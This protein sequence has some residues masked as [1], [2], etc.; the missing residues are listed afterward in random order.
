MGQQAIY[1]STRQFIKYWDSRVTI[2]LYVSG[3]WTEKLAMVAREF[4]AVPP[5]LLSIIYQKALLIV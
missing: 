1:I 3:D 4:E 5:I 2:Y